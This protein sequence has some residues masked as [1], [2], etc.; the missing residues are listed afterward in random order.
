MMR[1]ISSSV[2]NLVIFPLQDILGLSSE[3]RMN[4]PGQS[5]GSWEWRFSWEQVEPRHTQTLAEMTLEYARSPT[6][7][8]PELRAHS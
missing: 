8:K 7:T 5:T 4:C 1:A 2:A 3:H 6:K